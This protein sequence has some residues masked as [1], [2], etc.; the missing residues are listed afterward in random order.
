MRVAM[1]APINRRVP[2]RPYGLEEQMISDLTEGLVERGHQVTLFATGNSL[3][4]AEL[5]SVCPEP[6]VEWEEDPWPDPQ[7]WEKLHITE[8]Q[9]RAHAG[10]FD[11]VHN[12]LHVKALSCLALLRVPVLTTLHGAGRDKQIQGLL[13]KFNS[14]PYVAMDA[15]EKRLLPELNYVAEIPLPNAEHSRAIPNMV[16]S[17]E[18]LYEKVV[19][20]ELEPPFAEVRRKCA[21]GAS[22]L[23]TRQDAFQVKKL[24]IEAG[25]RLEYARRELEKHW[26]VISGRGVLTG[27]AGST[28]L[29]PGVSLD[30]PAKEGYAVE[31]GADSGLVVI[32]VCQGDDIMKDRPDKTK[33]NS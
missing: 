8:C 22:E 21:W 27:P 30:P 12:H 32:E 17:Y 1:L 31:A 28:E 2:P 24:E 25:W 9:Q 4:R 19:S 29:V 11:L 14:Y 10:E 13:R 7:W 15:G 3:T 26:S 5:V 18:A 16:D 20:G 23:L 33:Q 6:L